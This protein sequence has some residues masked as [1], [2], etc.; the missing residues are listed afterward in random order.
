MSAIGF[1][2]N[3][4]GLRLAH[5]LFIA[6]VF[7]T[8]FDIFLVLNVGFN[9]R[10]NQLFLLLP[11]LIATIKSLQYR[12]RWP[13]G[14]DWLVLW[15]VFILAF[16]P[17]T[18][19]LTKSVGYAAWLVFNVLMV[20]ACVQIF[21]TQLRLLILLK[22]YVY[23]FVFVSFFGLV[24]FVSPLLGLG[25][26]FLV[27]AWW[28]PG[29]L[30]RLNGF[31]YEPSF[32]AT[33]LLI[34]WVFCAVLLELKS[35]LFKRS[36]LRFYFAVISLSLF[37]SGS[38]MGI[39]MMLVWYLQYPVRFVLKLIDGHIN[40]RYALI[41]LMLLFS[42]ML[43]IGLVL[44]FIGLHDLLF[45]FDGLGIFGAASHSVDT[46]EGR[47]MET[48]L[49][50]QNSPFIGYSLGG[51][52]PA[53]AQLNGVTDLDFESIKEF[54]GN[55]IFVEVLAASGIFGFIPFVLFVMSIV[56]K[57]F[58]L[59]KKLSPDKSKV[60]VALTLSLIF[61]F[62]ILQFNQVILRPYLWMHIAV[63]AACYSVFAS[64]DN[65]SKSRCK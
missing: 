33:Y 50:F 42:I 20:Y 61:E 2:K 57:P 22:W 16:V 14:F 29:V 15:T 53:I 40:E 51:I 9:F 19:Y 28:I 34:G 18:I 54:E 11:M 36:S 24:Q 23:S 45:L 41:I 26:L 6:A 35:N 17:N 10:I 32:Y 8:S 59:S 49:L 7:T 60:L 55:S 5:I 43:P 37:L 47:M 63:L 62:A 30:P 65:F 46:R 4:D 44:Y 39:L 64:R 38:R 25:D 1:P 21:S 12:V 3:T 48:L 27:Q 52:A 31:S 13:V 56:L 58:A